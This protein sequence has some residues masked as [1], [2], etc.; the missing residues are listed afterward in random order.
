MRTEN[1]CKENDYATGKY[2][3]FKVVKIEN[4]N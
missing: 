4:E 2:G 1:A 3:D